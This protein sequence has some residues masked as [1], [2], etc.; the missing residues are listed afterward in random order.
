[1]APPDCP[2]QGPIDHRLI[3]PQARSWL[4]PRSR[5]EA[6]SRLEAA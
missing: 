6:Q 2:R 4:E 5:M 3:H 1:M